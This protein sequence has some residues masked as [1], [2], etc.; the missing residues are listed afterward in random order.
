RTFLVRNVAPAFVS[1]F[2]GPRNGVSA[3]KLLSSLCVVCNDHARV[4]TVFGLAAPA[5]KNFTLCNNW[6]RGFLRRTLLK[7]QD[8]VFPNQ[9]AGSGIEGEDEVVGA[10]VDDRV[11][12]N[13]EIT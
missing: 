8:P 9:F 11:A 13:S 12:I 2:S 10:G 7:I 1:R 3:P 5:R 6:A 4:R